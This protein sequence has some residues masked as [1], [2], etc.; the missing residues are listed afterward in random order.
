M[1]PDEILRMPACTDDE[2]A[3]F[4]IRVLTYYDVTAARDAAYEWA[5][6]LQRLPKRIRS[7][8][9]IFTLRCPEN[10]TIAEIF[11]RRRGE[12]KQWLLM[13]FTQRVFRAALVN[14]VMADDG[15]DPD[16]WLPMTC[17]HGKGRFDLAFAQEIAAFA[18]P[19]QRCR[20]IP[21]ILVLERSN[22]EFVGQW[23]LQRVMSWTQTAA[24]RAML[25]PTE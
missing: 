18:L 23:K 6:R 16:L 22:R 25:D 12:G 5:D 17:R 4:R 21:D 13:T 11:E 8:A 3:D 19:G 20:R 24:S 7:K 14:R 2:E 15:L 1:S 10:C 9:C